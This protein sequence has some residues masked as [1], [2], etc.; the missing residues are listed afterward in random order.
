I[1]KG[2]TTNAVALLDG[3]VS[4]QKEDG[5]IEGADRSITSSRGRDLHIETTALALLGWLKADPGKYQ[6]AIKKSVSWLG[7]QRGG[8][9]GYGST[10]STILALK[11]LIE[12]TR[13]QP[14][15]VKPGELK[16]FVGTA[17]EPAASLKFGASV[18]DTLTL[19]L[20]KAEELLKAG[21]N[22]MRIEITGG[23]ALPYTLSCSSRTRRPE[24]AAACSLTL[25][26][27]M[28]DKA[29]EGEVVHLKVALTNKSTEGQGMAVA[30]IGLPGGLTLPEDMKQLTGYTRLPDDGTRPLIAAF[31]LRGREL[32]LYWR[33]LQPGQK[34]E[35]PIDLVCRVPGEYTGPA[36]RAYLYYQ[37]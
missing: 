3:I 16:L 26:T 23:N 32:V 4:G 8:Y 14:R 18:P 28:P 1:N 34:I 6:P 12:Y 7:K 30:I 5:H 13:R 19:P 10:Q 27:A 37:A 29:K 36:S 25:S 35:V 33:D 15:E 21:D 17:T 20:A 11:A 31:E 22:K 24:S 9:G 2:R